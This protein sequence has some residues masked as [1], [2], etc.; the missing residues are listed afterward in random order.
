MP[1][2]KAPLSGVRVRQTCSLSHNEALTSH[3]TWR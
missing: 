3:C 2:P 1:M